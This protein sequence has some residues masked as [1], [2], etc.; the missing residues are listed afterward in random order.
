MLTGAKKPM[1]NDPK[2][3]AALKSF[4]NTWGPIQISQS[5]YDDFASSKPDRSLMH[6]LKMMGQVETDSIQ[7]LGNALASR[8]ADDAFLSEFLPRWAAEETE[9]GSILRRLYEY[10]R[11]NPSS[12]GEVITPQSESA[13]RKDRTFMQRNSM[14]GLWFFSRAIP[15]F[16]A[17][18]SVFGAV[19]EHTVIQAYELLSKY[20]NNASLQL[21]LQ[22]ILLQE[23][24]HFAVYYA[25]AQDRL[26]QSNVQRLVSWQLHRL[27]KPV[28]FEAMGER[29]WDQVMSYLCR[30][31]EDI[32]QFERTDQVIS[33]L[34]G[35]ENT[36]LME[37]A[38][39]EWSTRNAD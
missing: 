8:T 20:C 31:N 4:L 16:D 10:G 24:R 1:R 36:R 3:S 11:G 7:Q 29:N 33:R 21:V 27:W 5:I 9:H 37:F 2:T 19:Q 30:S 17:L 38:M 13:R 28:G 22:Q 18:Y 32:A 26:R 6:V 14:V 23:R 15:H 35:L 34:P 25:E 12:I 39:K